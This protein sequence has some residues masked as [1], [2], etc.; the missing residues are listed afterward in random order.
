MIYKFIYL[1]Y[2]LNECI[3]K[4]QLIEDTDF[5]VRLNCFPNESPPFSWRQIQDVLDG[6]GAI[7]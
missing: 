4:S 3:A 6:H 5:Q 1:H 2:A 7:I